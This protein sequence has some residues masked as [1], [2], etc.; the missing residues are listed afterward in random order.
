MEPIVIEARYRHSTRPWAIAVLLIF[1]L[2][3]LLSR[4]PWFLLLALP[5]LLLFAAVWHGRIRSIVFDD[6][7]RVRRVRDREQIFAFRDVRAI[8][9]RA[10]RMRRGAIS[11]MDPLGNGT[12]ANAAEIEAMFRVLVEQGIVP[13]DELIP[14]EE[15]EAEQRR[16]L[17]S[18]LPAAIG[19]LIAV[20]LLAIT[21]RLPSRD[22]LAEVL[23]MGLFLLLFVLFYLL[24]RE[25]S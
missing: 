14:D 24:Q 25:R 16:V 8:T 20:V 7:I 6:G 22:P 3:T 10:I 18:L 12:L 21:G 1:P 5:F 17:R 4:L 11:L 15:I 19:T 13:R 2:L 9:H 23:A